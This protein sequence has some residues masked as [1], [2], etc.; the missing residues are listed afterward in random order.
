MPHW[1]YV[2][3]R[4]GRIVPW[5]THIGVPA[6]M[7]DDFDPPPQLH[8][9]LDD[10]ERMLVHVF[11]RRYVTWCARTRRFVQ[12]QGAANLDRRVR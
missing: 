11:L 10:R 3:R 6:P 8:P 9:T 1:T 7:I 4:R 5:Q 2:S 12:M